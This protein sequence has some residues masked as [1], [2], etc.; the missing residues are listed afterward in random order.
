MKTNTH[1]SQASLLSNPLALA[2][3]RM[4]GMFRQ[5][6]RSRRGVGGRRQEE[7]ESGEVS[8]GLERSGPR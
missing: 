3:W 4:N 2:P 1:E 5:G 7:E 8:F 6:R